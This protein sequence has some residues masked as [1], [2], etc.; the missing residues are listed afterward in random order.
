MLKKVEGQATEEKTVT[1]DSKIVNRWTK[2]E[3]ESGDQAESDHQQWH[4]TYVGTASDQGA[5]EDMHRAQAN[6]AKAKRDK[7]CGAVKQAEAE[8]NA[9]T[10]QSS[11]ALASSKA[12]LE[13]AAQKEL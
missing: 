4:R 10:A 12:L 3:D 13:F 7:A 8:M 1:V 2:V 11:S 9:L 5:H 6:E